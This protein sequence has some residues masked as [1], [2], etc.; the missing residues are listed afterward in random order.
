MH[1]D[2][3]ASSGIHWL[4]SSMEGRVLSGAGAGGVQGMCVGHFAFISLSTNEQEQQI[5]IIWER[6]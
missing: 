3:Y 5:S 1:A 4:V 6:S 2:R